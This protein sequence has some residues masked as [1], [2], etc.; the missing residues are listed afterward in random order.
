MQ[1]LIVALISAITSILTV[2]IFKP[3]ADRKLLK[4]QL[5]QNYISEQS[6][7]VKEHI[8]TFKGKLLTSAELL[9]TRLK[10]FAKNHNEPWLNSNNNYTVQNHYMDTTV[11]RFLSFFANIQLIEKNLNYLDTTIS[12]NNDLRML[13]FFRIFHECMCDVDLFHGFEYNKNLPTDHFFTTPFYNLSNNLIHKNKVIDLDKYIETKLEILPKIISVYKFFDG[14]NPNEDRLRCER[15]KCFHLLL[16]SF[17]NEYGYDYQ[18]TDKKQQKRIKNNLGEY[19]LLD[20][21]EFL[22]KKFKL[23]KICGQIQKVIANVR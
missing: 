15:L 17:L 7:K 11:Y 21:L 19:R 5:K 3:F 22:V 23:K 4:F 1:E 13:K 9:N 10:N 16:I 6:K 18:R 20:N 12:Q 2:L 8:A 14:I